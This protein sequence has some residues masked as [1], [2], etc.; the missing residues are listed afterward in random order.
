[1][2]TNEVQAIYNGGQRGQ[3]RC[4]RTTHDHCSTREP[5]G[6]RRRYGDFAW[7]RF[8]TPPLGYQCGTT[9]PTLAV[10]M[11]QRYLTNVQFSDAAVIWS[12]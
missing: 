10:P 2:T 7:P 4:A 1:L 8:G 9:E 12:S 5:D 6:H 3:M 11:V